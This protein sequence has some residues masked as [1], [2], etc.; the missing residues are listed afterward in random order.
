MTAWTCRWL[1]AVMFDKNQTASCKQHKMFHF[2]LLSS[3]CN[4]A[5]TVRLEMENYFKWQTCFKCNVL[6]TTTYVTG[7]HFL[8][9]PITPTFEFFTQLLKVIWNHNYN[10]LQVVKSDTAYTRKILRNVLTWIIS[11][12]LHLTSQDK[13][14]IYA[15]EITS[16]SAT[17][18]VLGDRLFWKAITMR[19][20]YCKGHS[21]PVT[22]WE[23]EKCWQWPAQLKRQGKDKLPEIKVTLFKILPDKEDTRVIKK[24]WFW[25]IKTLDAHLL[26][27]YIVHLN[28]TDMFHD[29]TK[30]HKSEFYYYYCWKAEE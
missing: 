25:Y 3:N 17:D 5:Q 4:S 21:C 26:V 12:F 16:L 18:E 15:K 29:N 27:C 13:F 10:I 19:K 8:L 7:W 24:Y 6:L 11:G 30:T 28:L 2:S 23:S 20:P 22:A 9:T 14:W 1:P